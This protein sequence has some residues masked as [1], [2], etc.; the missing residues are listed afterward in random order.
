VYST[1][2]YILIVAV[3]IYL[4][5][6]VAVGLWAARRVK[7]STDYV[8]AGHKLPLFMVVATTFATWFGSET[9]LGTSSTFIQEG[10][11]GIVADPFGA[12]MCLILVGLFFA[13]PLYHL[14]LLTIGDYYRQRYGR[15][16][17]IM[18][19]VVIAL[20]YLGWVAAQLA[21]LGLVFNVITHDAI[22]I[23]MGII[24]G[25]LIVTTYTIFGGMWSVALTDFIQMTLIA[26]G[27]IYIS[28]LIS[29]QVDGGAT[30]VIQHAE[31]AGKLT[32][33]PEFSLAGWLGF[34]GALITLGFGSIPQQDI[35]QRVLSANS[36][37]NARRGAVIG[38]VLY[39]LFA[40]LPI[41]LAYTAFIIS[42]DMVNSALSEDG[43][44]QLV[45]PTLILEHTPIFVQIIFFGALLSAIMST[46]SATLLAPSSVISENLFSK[47]FHQ[48]TETN[49]L[50]FLRATVLVFA[51]LV[52]SYALATDKSIFEMVES[53]YKVVL[54]GAFV[55]LAFG[56]Y[57]QRASQNGARLAIFFG[58]GTWLIFE[59]LD[60]T[61]GDVTG[62][63][64]IG[65]ADLATVCPPQLAGFI[66]SVIGMLIGSMISPNK[67]PPLR[68]SELLRKPI[69]Q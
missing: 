54:V 58:V 20:S 39:L 31:A 1:N 44:S 64:L 48:L 26:A 52:T 8:V 18:T 42:P 35:Y 27:L 32:I 60:S 4:A 29:G 69:A 25:V 16:I 38:G 57:W 19:S 23:Q 15:D 47:I 14:R 5:I 12:A 22:S 6:N 28:W 63:A 17:E 24:I 36:A 40:M 37:K 68:P 34:I 30:A 43:N 65:H 51:V 9:V 62:W 7:N 53:A 11:G 49:K 67:N 55:P 50:K 61:W 3:V 66:F 21:A 56:L 13:V 10:M 46:A 33:L 45:L 59:A 41:Y 2:D